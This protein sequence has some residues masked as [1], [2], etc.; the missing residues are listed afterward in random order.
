[1]F[2]GVGYCDASTS[3]AAL[4]VADWKRWEKAAVHNSGA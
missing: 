4:V 2:V 1:M 3:E